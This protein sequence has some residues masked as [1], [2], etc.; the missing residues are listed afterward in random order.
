[1]SKI[2]NTDLT[3]NINVSTNVTVDEKTFYTCLQL[4]NSYGLQEGLKG[5]VLRFD[6]NSY[7]AFTTPVIQV[8]RT[9]EDA[10]QAMMA[11]GLSG[12]D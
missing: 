1:M 7:S 2:E 10:R 12:K 4:L 3:V 9:E 8:L 6:D 11:V 5:V